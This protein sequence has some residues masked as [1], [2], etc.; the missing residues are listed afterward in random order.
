MAD[1]IRENK[2][3]EIK[4]IALKGVALK[5]LFKEDFL[6]KLES[7]FN[8]FSIIN[9]ALIVDDNKPSNLISIGHVSSEDSENNIVTIDVKNEEYLNKVLEILN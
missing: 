2:N 3:V 1:D 6:E 5:D 7:N 4:K 9:L 8:N